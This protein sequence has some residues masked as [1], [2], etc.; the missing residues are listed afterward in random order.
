MT[1][2]SIPFK[3]LGIRNKPSSTKFIDKD[4]HFEVEA[5]MDRRMSPGQHTHEYLVKWKNY[6]V[7]FNSWITAEDFDDLKMI[8][9]YWKKNTKPRTIMPPRK[10]QRKKQKSAKPVKSAN[11]SH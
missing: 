8:K 4:E 10:V 3:N 6:N 1:K 2:L 5:I 11:T 7:S 9:T